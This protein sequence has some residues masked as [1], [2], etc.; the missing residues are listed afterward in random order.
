[1]G[2]GSREKHLCQVLSE[3]YLVTQCPVGNWK[4]KMIYPM[5]AVVDTCPQ[6]AMGEEKRISAS[7]QWRMLSDTCS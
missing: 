3:G 1:M 2:D 5:Y 7:T 6:W 4:K